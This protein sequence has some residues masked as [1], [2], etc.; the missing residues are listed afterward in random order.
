MDL[1]DLLRVARQS[2]SE[3]LQLHRPRSLQQL[4]PLQRLQNQQK[5]AATFSFLR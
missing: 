2:G 5:G 1:Q 4:V 3:D